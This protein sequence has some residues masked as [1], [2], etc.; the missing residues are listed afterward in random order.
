MTVNKIPFRPGTKAN[1]WILC[2]CLPL[3]IPLIIGALAL[4]KGKRIVARYL[5]RVYCPLKI[6]I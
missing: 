6:D 5:K 4:G 2:L 1:P 3:Q